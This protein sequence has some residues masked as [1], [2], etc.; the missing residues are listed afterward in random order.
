MTLEGEL[1]AITQAEALI[2]QAKDII[3]DCL[4]MSFEAEDELDTWIRMYI[5]PAQE[6]LRD[7]IKAQKGGA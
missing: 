2:R 5:T 4:E 7:D 1:H 6:A 3:H